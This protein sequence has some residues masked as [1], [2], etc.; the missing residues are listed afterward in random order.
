MKRMYDKPDM[1]VVRIYLGSPLLE[2][3]TEDGGFS[4]NIGDAKEQDG[5][6]FD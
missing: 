2:S 3:S 5:G 4:V 1:T 6:S